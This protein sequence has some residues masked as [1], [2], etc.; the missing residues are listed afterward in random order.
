MKKIAPFILA[1]ALV[2]AAYFALLYVVRHY[3]DG[4]TPTG[5]G[6]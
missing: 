2:L 3:A 5:L 6:G 4:Q 1:A